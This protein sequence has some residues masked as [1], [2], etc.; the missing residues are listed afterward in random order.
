MSGLRFTRD[1]RAIEGLPIR[2][3]IAV[4]VGTA[5]LSLMLGILA[6]SEPSHPTEVT[7]ETDDADDLIVTESSTETVTLSIIDEN[8]RTVTDAV[9]II[10]SDTAR[11]DQAYTFETGSSDNDVEIDFD[12]MDV[13]LFS[14]QQSGELEVTIRPPTDSNWVDEEPNPEIVIIDG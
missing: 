1:T 8:G 2:L 14:G 6:D 13:E 10:E 9:V 4:I 3:V 5:A 12:Q 11:V 7:F